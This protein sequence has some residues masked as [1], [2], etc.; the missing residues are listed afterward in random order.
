MSTTTGPS[1][2]EERIPRRRVV[3]WASWDWGLASFNAVI[4][5]F[6]F[7]PYLAKAVAGTNAPPG[8]WS[9]QVWLGIA[10]AIAGLCIAL[11]APVLGQRADAGGHRK[12]NLAIWS[13]LITAC[14]VGMFWVRDDFSYLWLGLVLLGLGNI[15][16]EI[17]SVSFNAMLHQVST[18]ATVGRVSGFGW[19]AGYVGGIF[20]LLMLYLGVIQPDVGWFGA[21]DEGGYRYRL[22]ALLSA[23]WFAVFALPLF[24]AVPEVSASGPRQRTS[25]L[26]S[27]RTLFR[28]LRELW[29]SDRNSVFFLGA[30]ALF[31]DG[32]AAVF[33]FGAVLA[34]TVFG[35]EQSQVLIFGVA[36]NVVAAGG[37]FLGGLLE[38]RLG[39][40]TII[41]VSL[42]GLVVTASVLLFVHSTTVFWVLGLALCLWVGPAQSSSRSFL[43][44]VSPE[45]REGQMFGLYATTGRAVSFLAPAMVAGFSLLGGDRLGIV[46]IILTLLL[47]LGAVSLVKPPRRWLE[48]RRARADLQGSSDFGNN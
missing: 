38:D 31:R 46:G 18:P 24:F 35:L 41:I 2:A 30:S 39:P 34:V 47:G 42:A 14:M 33:S 28:D 12:R 11:L 15:F 6:V 9:G 22:V 3:A 1:V 23:V 25:L 40:K 45:G 4:T 10:T 20:L 37:A 21:T 43:A 26:E 19:G 13:A 32:L 7:G 29:R 36:A 8:A 16:S 5:T 48:A 17:A 27:F 44:Q